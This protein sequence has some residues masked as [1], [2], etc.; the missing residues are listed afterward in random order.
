MPA[1]CSKGRR[2]VFL[3]IH[4]LEQRNESGYQVI[5]TDQVNPG[6]MHGYYYKLKHRSLGTHILVWKKKEGELRTGKSRCHGT[7][8]FFLLLNSGF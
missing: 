5:W 2:Q 8:G 6:N 4:H 1:I 3:G 7:G